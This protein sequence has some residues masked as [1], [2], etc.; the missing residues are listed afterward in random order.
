MASSTAGLVRRLAHFSRRLL[1]AILHLLIWGSWGLIRFSLNNLALCVGCRTDGFDVGGG[2]TDAAPGIHGSVKQ[3][4]V[5]LVN[6]V[7]PM[8]TFE[9]VPEVLDRIEFR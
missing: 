9:V 6:T 2:E 7:R 3:R 8:M 4:V 1:K 5:V